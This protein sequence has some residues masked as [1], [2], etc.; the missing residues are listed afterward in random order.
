MILHM[1]SSIRGRLLQTLAGIVVV[2][3]ATS[4]GSTPSAPT[5]RST[6][7]AGSMT[8]AMTLTETHSTADLARCLSGSGDAACF[9]ASRE[10]ASAASS[11]VTSAPFNLSA[12]VSGTTVFLS[13]TQPTIQDNPVISYIVE[14]GS[15][16]GAVDLA[17][18]NIGNPSTSLTVL[19][20][21]AGLYFVRI[22]AVNAF[23]AS[24]VSN[25]VIVVVGAAACASAPRSLTVVSQGVGTISLSWA[26]P[27]S[28]S[29]LSYVIQAGSAPGRS[30]L[31]DFDTN[32]A[33][34][35]FGAAG[36]PA[37]LYY[38]R[39]YAR[40]ANAGCGLSGPSN[41]IQ[42]FMLGFPP[43]AVS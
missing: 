29:V 19:S 8:A 9:N 18:F 37:G 20:V 26:A 21:P 35:S 38:V 10:T 31:A 13:W 15:A 43:P 23:G 27:A 7:A 42:A 30:D 25:E 1:T 5:A 33:A 34:L 2:V 39:V 3:A 16:P 11:P 24:G 32:N 22:R 12:S 41:E 14:A 36:V 6:V 40:S 28:G 4:C 17:V